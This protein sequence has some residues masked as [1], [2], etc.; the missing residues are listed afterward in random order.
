MFSEILLHHE[1]RTGLFR[2]ELVL[3]GGPFGPVHVYITAA[4]TSEEDCVAEINAW[5][6]HDT[7]PDETP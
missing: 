1:P 5:I 4:H 3:H 7:M 6:E 2:A